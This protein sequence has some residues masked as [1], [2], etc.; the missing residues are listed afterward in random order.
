[1]KIGRNAGPPRPQETT[2]DQSDFGPE[3][4]AYKVED[5]QIFGSNFYLTGMYSM[6]N[7]GF[8]LVPEGGARRL[9][10]PRPPACI[11]HNSFLL[12]QTERPQEQGKAR[13]LAAS[14]TPAASRH[15]LK[16]GAGYRTAEQST[17][18]TLAGRRPR[19][20]LLRRPATPTSLGPRPRRPA[21]RSR[22]TTP[23]PTLQ[24]TLTVGNL[25]ANVG[26][27]YDRQGGE[28]LASTRA[29]PT[30]SFPDLLPAVH[31]AGEDAGFDLD[32]RSPRASA[33]PTPSARSAR[34]CCA[35]ATRGS[36]TSSAP[37]PPASSTRSRAP[38]YRYF[39]HLPTTA[40]PRWSPAT[41]GP[42]IA[43]AER[44]RQPLHPGSRCS[45]TR[46][47][48]TSTLRSPTSCCSAPSTP[49]C[50]ISWSA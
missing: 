11:W 17:L 48:P 49:C 7:G 37:A 36:P 27:R 38:R 1:M 2:W 26:L 22:P 5:T 41:I 24:D 34:P 50:R 4:T 15:E 30:R 16:F 9:A 8:Q 35:P 46:S 12:N 13:R 43:S 23:A 47:T 28:N 10:V 44:Q 20:R 42:E 3:P 31:Y 29:R 21:P 33:S 32:R 6:V 14:S 18:V 40:A 19:A 25:T 45:P 39:L